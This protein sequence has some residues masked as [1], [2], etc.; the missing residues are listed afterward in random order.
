MKY[1][2]IQLMKLEEQLSG[3]A[4]LDCLFEPKTRTVDVIFVHGL[5]GDPQSTWVREGS[6]EFWPDWLKS[7]FETASIYSLGYPASVFEKWAKKEM[8]MFERAG[9]MLE[10]MAGLGLGQRPLAFI[11][12]SL[13]G[14]LAKILLR[15]SCESEDSDWRAISQSTSLVIFLSTPH[16]GAALASALDVLPLSSKHI[17]LLGN[18]TGFLEDLNQQYRTYANGSDHLSTVAYYESYKTKK[19]AVVVDRASADPG[20]AGTTPVALDKDHINVCKPTSQSDTLFL[21]ICRHLKKIVDMA[22]PENGL[23]LEGYSEKSEDDRRDLL[24][25]LIDAG[26]EHEYHHANNAQNRFARKYMRTGL[27]SAA[28]DDHDCFLSEIE[29]RFVTHI[30]HPLICQGANDDDIRTALQSEVIDPLANKKTGGTLFDAAS[31]LNGLYYLTEQ[32]Y[33]R[34]DVAA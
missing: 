22:Q 9:N 20:V 1:N 24:Q 5:T 28:R 19:L 14:I 31:V 34:W 7:K 27:L 10:Q 8:D 21:G 23:A 32:C 33:I 17:K 15:K 12:H 26:R 30:Y 3:Q 2:S 13:G 16:A 29:A 4:T 6:D 18:D 11:T 25:K